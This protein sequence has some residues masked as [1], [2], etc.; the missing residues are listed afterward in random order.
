M[1]TQAVEPVSVRAKSNFIG[2]FRVWM[3]KGHGVL[4]G[5]PAQDARR[6]HR[7][8]AK[9]ARIVERDGITGV[10]RGDDRAEQCSEQWPPRSGGHCSAGRAT[11]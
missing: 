10:L 7:D 3:W 1:R 11:V 9:D 6:A 5:R 4:D 8:V 2:L